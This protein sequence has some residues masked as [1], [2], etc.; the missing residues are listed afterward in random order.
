MLKK[1]LDEAWNHGYC[2][3]P[4]LPCQWTAGWVTTDDIGKAFLR[5]LNNVWEFWKMD[6]KE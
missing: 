5:C 2:L 3:N 1:Q 6:Y 4:N